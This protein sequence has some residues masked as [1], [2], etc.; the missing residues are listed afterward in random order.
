MKGIILAGGLGTRLYPIT[1]SIS[2]QLLPIYD[3]PMIYYPL[4]VLMLTGLQEIMIIS[5]E[6]DIPAYRQL[7]SDGSQL[8]MRFVY[9]VQDKPRGLAESFILGKEFIG[10][11]SVCLVLGDNIFFGRGF[12]EK[13]QNA[14]GLEQ[15]AVIFGY[16]LQNPKEFG[17][18]EFD[19]NGNV[20]SIEEKPEHPKSNYAIPG[21]YF[22][23]NQVISISENLKPS[24]RGELEITDVNREYMARRQLKVELLGRGMAW[25]D[26]GTCAGLIQAATFVE[27]VQNRQGMYI[28]CI[29]EIAY[30]KGFINKKQA[31]ELA[32]SMSKTEYGKYLRNIVEELNLP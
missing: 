10:N 7:L 9:K 12:S 18:V 32:D 31:L 28:A 15:G 26:T 30:R 11:D 17:V 27:T 29:E 19:T 14:A 5:T 3:K 16:H 13:L 22:Y 6:R 23:D 2:K 24:S 25:L 4:S 8:G 1:K 21:L 20:L